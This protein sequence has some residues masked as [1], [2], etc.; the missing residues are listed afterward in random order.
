MARREPRSTNLDKSSFSDRV[1]TT[2]STVSGFDSATMQRSTCRCAKESQS[3]ISG[4]HSTS[5]RPELEGVLVR[6]SKLKTTRLREGP[7]VVTS[8]V[9]EGRE[10]T[11]DVTPVDR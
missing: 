11:E 8:C 9:M 3:M 5:C 2:S 4:F 7:A 6:H 1:P 10:E